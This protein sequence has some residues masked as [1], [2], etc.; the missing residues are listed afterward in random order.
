MPDTITITDDR[1]GQSVTVPIE[2]GTFPSSAI[3]ELDRNL[4]MYDPAFGIF[5]YLLN[6]VGIGDVFWLSDPDIATY[7]LMAVDV[8]QFTPFVFLLLYAGLLAL[9]APRH[10]EQVDRGLEHRTGHPDRVVHAV[11]GELGAVPRQPVLEVR[12]PCLRCPDMQV[13]DL[14]HGGILP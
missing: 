4:F 12:R 10:V 8:W 14:C 7:A 2:H 11:L 9:P 3:R 6:T 13:D 5:N 1:T